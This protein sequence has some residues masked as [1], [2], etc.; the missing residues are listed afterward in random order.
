MVSTFISSLVNDY[1]QKSDF[2]KKGVEQLIFNSI[3]SKP[4]QQCITQ[5]IAN[6]YQ[7]GSNHTRDFIR[8][9]HGNCKQISKALKSQ[10]TE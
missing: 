7:Y 8:Q 1:P 6:F 10:I 3:D 5:L 9:N 4:F 2:Y